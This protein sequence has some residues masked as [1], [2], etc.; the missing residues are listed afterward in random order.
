MPRIANMTAWAAIRVQGRGAGLA[1]SSMFKNSYQSGYLSIL[2]SIGTK[3]L[4]LW[5]QQGG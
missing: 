5:E 4:Q 3:P 1:A 2:Y